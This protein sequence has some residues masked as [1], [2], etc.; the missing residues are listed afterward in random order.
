MHN[1]SGSQV[2]LFAFLGCLNLVA[3]LLLLGYSQPHRLILLLVKGGLA[4]GIN[5]LVVAANQ[6]LGVRLELDHLLDSDSAALTA[7]V[8]PK[9]ED[10][11]LVDALRLTQLVVIEFEAHELFI[12]HKLELSAEVRDTSRVKVLDTLEEARTVAATL[13][14]RFFTKCNCSDEDIRCLN[15]FLEISQRRH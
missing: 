7:A 9:V 3:L 14:E 5:E 1:L 4:L 15:K 6:L 13:V 10:S 12:S 11:L 8:K 2:E